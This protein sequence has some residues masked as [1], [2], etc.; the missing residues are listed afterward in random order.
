VALAPPRIQ[1]ILAS[2]PVAIEKRGLM[3]DVNVAMGDVA[4][5]RCDLAVL[6]DPE[7]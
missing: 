1:V 7:Q 6:P 4:V 3:G 5:G 2:A